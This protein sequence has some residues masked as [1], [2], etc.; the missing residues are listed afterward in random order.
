M[1]DLH[2]SHGLNLKPSMML[3]LAFSLERKAILHSLEDH[4]NPQSL[5][6]S[7]G[8]W[9][10]WSAQTDK[11]VKEMDSNS[12]VLAYSI[13]APLII[14]SLNRINLKVNKLIL[15]SPAFF[16]RGHSFVKRLALKL[17]NKFPIP[18]FNNA[19][20]RCSPWLALG[21]YRDIIEQLNIPQK[22][23][24]N[25]CW[26]AIHR[27]DE[28]LDASQT[29]AWAKQVKCQATLLTKPYLPSFHATY[30]P[31]RLPLSKLQKYLNSNT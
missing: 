7:S 11:W 25:S 15:L 24:A 5:T 13:T 31:H 16:F 8:H 6:L 21:M 27:Y 23:P 2:I 20:A 3:P 29:L 19:S 17:P 10:R 14:D 30:L 22:I 26:L 9:Q 18:S 28:L 4:E 12:D 1:K